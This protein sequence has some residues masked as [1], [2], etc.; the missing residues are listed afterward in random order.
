MLLAICFIWREIALP[1]VEHGIVLADTLKYQELEEVGD[2]TQAAP[3]CAGG[4]L[5]ASAILDILS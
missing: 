4:K 5:S 2:C 3:Y 1:D